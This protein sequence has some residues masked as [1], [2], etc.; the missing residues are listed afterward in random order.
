M[1]SFLN[2]MYSKLNTNLE[3]LHYLHVIITGEETRVSVTGGKASRPVSADM[4]P[5]DNA[6]FDDD[7]LVHSFE[8]KYQYAKV[9]ENYN[10][11]ILT[12]GMV[13]TETTLLKV[14]KDVEVYGRLKLEK[15]AFIHILYASQRKIQSL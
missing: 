2:K 13:A 8:Y 12:C 6:V 4:T 15:R 1:F 11:L 9:K 5:Q 3:D 10:L 14:S 7:G